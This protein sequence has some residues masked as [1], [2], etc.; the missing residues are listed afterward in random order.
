[1]K[2]IE[3]VE[4]W[5]QFELAMQGPA[6]GNPFVDVQLGA[7][8]KREGQLFEAEGFYDGNGIYRIRF[9]PD[10]EGSWTYTTFSNCPGLDGVN[11]EFVCSPAGAGNHG[12]VEAGGAVH[13][14]YADG[15][16]YIP[17]GTTC[18]V[19]HLQGGEVRE[20]TL[21]TLKSS[22]FNKIRMCIFPKSYLFN[23]SEPDTYPYE[24][25]SD[26]PKEEAVQ[27]KPADNPNSIPNSSLASSP[28]SSLDSSLD[29]NPPRNRFDYTRFNP[30]YFTNLENRIRELSELGIEADLILFHPY[31]EGRWG[32]DRMSAEEDEHY[33]RYVIA[34][35]GAFRNVWWSLANEYDLLEAKTTEDWDRL[36]R[37]IQECDYGSHLRSIHNCRE[38]YDYGKPW[39]T[40]ASIQSNDVKAV[41]EW[42]MNYG[43][44]VI[45]DECGYEGNLH[46][47]WG[48][49]TGEELVCRI[50][51]GVFR[52]GYV[53]HGET[54]LQRDND[55]ELWWS[56]G[57]TLYGESTDRIAF[58]RSLLE[59]AP[60]GMTYSRTWHDASTLALEG[61]YY[62]QYFGPHRFSFRQF[63]LPEGQYEVEIIDTWNMTVTSI[64]QPLEG[65]FRIDL[66]SELYYA[67]RI[68]RIPG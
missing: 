17:V 24:I 6:K 45:V 28:D 46:T 9:M 47:R 64:Q 8:F 12:K 48:S 59:E 11:G 55:T 3:Q 57:G 58:L 19:W 54:Y 68:R 10:E 7:Q 44:P 42:T 50:W 61:E 52:G 36:F 33:L 16:R 4:C 13:F 51:E 66:P 62:F 23:S 34:R 21:E 37:I 29:G 49:L 67:I 40:H 39:I 32:F 27:A 26:E 14:R 41:S 43:K 31:D 18:Y 60:D 2:T 65:S 22:P 53:T 63:K 1:M 38:L 25:L 30:A 35:L 15:T 5:G 56:H 20:R